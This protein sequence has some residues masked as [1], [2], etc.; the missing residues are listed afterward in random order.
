MMKK[1]IEKV[2]LDKE[3]AYN[4]YNK[5]ESYDHAKAIPYLITNLL[6]LQLDILLASHCL[7]IVKFLPYAKLVLVTHSWNECFFYVRF[8]LVINNARYLT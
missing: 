5:E 7:F 3:T 1:G 2:Q 8:L 6:L 4:V